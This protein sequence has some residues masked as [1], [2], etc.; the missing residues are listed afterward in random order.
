MVLVSFVMEGKAPALID[1]MPQLANN[2]K[3]STKTGS[4]LGTVIHSLQELVWNKQQEL[5]AGLIKVRE[6]V[7]IPSRESGRMV[8]VVVGV[9]VGVEMGVGTGEEMEVVMEIRGKADIEGPSLKA[10]PA[11][12]ALL[13]TCSLTGLGVSKKG[14]C[15]QKHHESARSQSLSPHPPK[16]WTGLFGPPACTDGFVR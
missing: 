8:L 12:V 15:R 11:S 5:E 14:E 16:N 7:N 6:V 9:E 4:S 1:T 10:I 2:V 3:N 13:S